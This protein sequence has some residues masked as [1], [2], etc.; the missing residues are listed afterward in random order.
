MTDQEHPTA[1]RAIGR[2]EGKID[3][4]LAELASWKAEHRQDHINIGRRQDA[5]DK[6]ITKI[7]G[8][9]SMFAVAGIVG[10]VSYLGDAKALILTIIA[11]LHV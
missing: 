2:V 5:S 11:R 7:E 10:V 4:L 6:R 8:R 1:D 3:V 9:I